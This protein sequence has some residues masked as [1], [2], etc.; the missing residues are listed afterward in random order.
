MQDRYDKAWDPGCMSDCLDDCSKID[1]SAV[2]SLGEQM[3][4]RNYYWVEQC[5]RKK[6]AGKTATFMC[7][8][9]FFIENEAKQ[10]HGN[11]TDEKIL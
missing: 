4:D 8:Y 6:Q 1:L 9:G 10:N 7:D 11:I 3:D 2:A 5:L